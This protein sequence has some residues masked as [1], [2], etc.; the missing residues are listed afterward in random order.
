MTTL[1]IVLACVAVL[2]C[3]L[4]VP[5][6]IRL[7]LALSGGLALVVFVPAGTIGTGVVSS[8]AGMILALIWMFV[9]AITAGRAVRFPRYFGLYIGV[10]ALGFLSA[11]VAN[12]VQPFNLLAAAVPLGMALLAGSLNTQEWSI[13]K[14]VII[15]MGLI[16]AA[17]CVV[18]SVVLK[19][20]LFAAV[21]YGVNPLLGDAIRGQGTLGHPLVAALTILV[22]FGLVLAS[23]YRVIVKLVL[24]AALFLGIVATGSTSAIIAAIFCLT[25]GLIV[26]GS[27]SSRIARFAIVIC[28]AIF[29]VTLSLVPSSLTDDVSGVNSVHRTNS[30]LAFPR[31]I[32]ERSVFESLFGSGWGSATSLYERNV[33][34]NDGFFAIDN[35]FTTIAAVSGLIGFLL[36]VSF[37][38]LILLKSRGAMRVVLLTL[39][40]MFASF[41]VLSW[42]ATSSL[43]VVCVALALREAQDAS[44]A[45]QQSLRP[46][47]RSPADL[48]A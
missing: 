40:V 15:V 32:T 7:A 22:G 9:V 31:L 19:A 18:E 42:V 33:L 35:Q 17:L 26:T 4:V 6:K 12:D 21:A 47:D 5:S 25:V 8:V 23:T 48:S 45:S 41:D 11:F 39:M 27:T 34:I 36:F 30:L 13:V 20:P 14:V 10:V 44:D 46:G 3:A 38:A 43:F 28:V 16:Q 29:V 1:L 24:M 37:L 2:V